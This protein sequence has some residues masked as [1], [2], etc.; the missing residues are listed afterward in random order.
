MKFQED[1]DDSGWAGRD[2]CDDEPL[3]EP[4]EWSEPDDDN[5]DSSNSDEN[6]N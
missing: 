4:E 2:P 3:P 1:N 6:N 5:S